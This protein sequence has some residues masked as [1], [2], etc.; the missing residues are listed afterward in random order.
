MKKLFTS[1]TVVV[2]LVLLMTITVSAAFSSSV[3]SNP[4]YSLNNNGI[5]YR[6]ATVSESGTQK[7]FYGEYDST[8]TDAEYEWV[9]HSIR[10]DST[11]TLSTVMK[12]AK[13]YE[14]K[15]GRKVMLAV[16]G[17][18]FYNTGENVDSYVNNGI[19]IKK[20]NMATKNCIGFDNNGKVV[21][22][23][24]TETEIR[25]VTYD[26][27]GNSQ[28]FE[29]DKFNEQP[30]SG[31]IAIYNAAGTYTVTNAGAMIVK[32]D[33]ANLNSY[34]VWGSDYTMTATGVQDSKTFT[35]TSGQY[36]VVYTSAH[37]DVFGKHVYGEK[38]DLVEI[39]AGE[40]A[41]CT[42][43]VG[44]Y[45]VLVDNFV[46]NTNCHTDN[47][48]N[49]AAPRTFI[50][51][52]EDGTGFVC[53]VDGRGAGGSTGITVNQEAQL[54][55]VLGA[56]YALELD[57][58]GS[59][60]MVV[61]INDTLTLRNSPSDGSMRAVSNAI[62]L[63]EKPKA[64]DT[65]EH[66]FVEGKCECGATDPNYN[67][68][69]TGGDHTHYWNAAT[70]TE[71]RTCEC[72]ETLGAALGHKYV[73][74]VCTRC[75]AEDPDYVPPHE[76]SFVEGKCECGEEDPDYVPDTPTQ[77]VETKTGFA[78]WIQSIIDAIMKF[79]MELFS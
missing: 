10:E 55:K 61:R 38:V 17:D 37:N 22:G 27:D 65:H 14:A 7:I 26:K 74:G 24:M 20:G 28:F 70:C 62:L 68:G 36:A 66:S 18:Y 43:V 57:G 51:F 52:K 67:G 73:D 71:P 11:T 72:G 2:A 1:L 44:G 78:A 8:G 53:V 5:K 47:S 59:S 13:D 16:N 12:I 75:Q 54:A 60:T 40:F 19:V 58:G 76:H 3:L 31:E 45:D 63:V 64:E 42:W 30:S 46:A 4:T 32:S 56:Q 41:G 29:V 9:V 23:R 21:V 6:E 79:F 34:P 77:P 69:S 48:G 25:L 50:G 39:P 35:L 49:S 15:T 33:S